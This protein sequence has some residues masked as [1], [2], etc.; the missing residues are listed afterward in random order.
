MKTEELIALALAGVAVYLIVKGKKP[1]AAA[2][3][4]SWKQPYSVDEI[5]DSNGSGFSNGWRYF[6]DGTSISPGGQYYLSGQYV[7][8]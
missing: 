1:A 2:S 5:L 8:G 6:N 3:S 4:A 7:Y